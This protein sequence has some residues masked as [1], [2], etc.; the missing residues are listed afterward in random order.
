[1][2]CLVMNCASIYVD[3]EHFEYPVMTAGHYPIV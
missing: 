2:M 3:S 1:M